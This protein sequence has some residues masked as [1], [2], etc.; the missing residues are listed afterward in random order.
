MFDLIII[1]GGPGGYAAAGFAARHELNVALVE[2]DRLGGTCLHRGCIPT[3]A[4]L[5]A[6]QAVNEA[7][8]YVPQALATFDRGAMLARK[9]EL[10]DTL[11]HGIE[12]MLQSA[13]VAVYEG[14]GTLLNATAPFS[15]RVTGAG[16]ETQ[17]LT[18]QK[19]ILSTGSTPARLP[20]PGCDSP[21]VWTSDDLLSASGAEP[22]QSLV[23]VGGGVI[24]V[25]MAYLYARLGVAVNVLEAEKRLLPMMDIELGR[26]AE[27]LLKGLG[28]MIATDARLQ[29]L[30]QTDA[31]FA[32]AYEKNGAAAVITAERALLATGRRPVTDRLLDEGA[33][34]T[35]ERR[36]VAVDD[37]YHTNIAGI[38]AVGDLNGR[39]QLAHAATAQGI[40]AVCDLLGIP[41]PVDPTLIPSCVY[42]APEIA[43]VGLTQEE[44]KALGYE[45]VIGKAVTTQNART[46]M[47]ALGRGFI[48]LV[49]DRATHKL[50]GAQLLCGRATEMVGELAL[51]IQNGLTAAELARVVRPHPTFEESITDAIHAA[52]F[53]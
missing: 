24:G 31:G 43:S 23:I 2:R 15:V 49:F 20:V 40:A 25:E 14:I 32:A 46:L 47:E 53:E 26:S 4:Y 45:I 21:D 35:T 52:R 22:F 11:T 3:K 18:G 38:Y 41:S 36:F 28:V 39:T 34:I 37:H 29:N 51:A 7:L 5:H 9:N 33:S 12:T 8:P 42:T 10:V 27:A 50:L 44:A 48:K 30:A 16:G 6:A 17:T 19:V 13:K 1:G